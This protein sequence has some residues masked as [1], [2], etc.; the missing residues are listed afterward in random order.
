MTPGDP[1]KPPSYGV[2]F[3][4]TKKK[5]GTTQFTD[6]DLLCKFVFDSSGAKLGESVSFME[7]M[8]IV[9]NGARFLGVPLKHVQRKDKSLLVKGIVDFSKAYE[10]GEKWQKDAR[11]EMPLHDKNRTE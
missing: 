6:Q 2:M 1:S 4:F 5:E 7:D 9:K 10:F 11:R 8:L 3:F